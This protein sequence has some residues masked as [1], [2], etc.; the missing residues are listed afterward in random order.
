MYKYMA[1]YITDIH[2]CARCVG[3]DPKEAF[4]DRETNICLDEPSHTLI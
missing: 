1:W 3:A 2:K 4:P